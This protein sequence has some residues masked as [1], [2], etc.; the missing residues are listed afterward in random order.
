MSIN[1]NLLTTVNTHFAIV[2]PVLS[3]MAEDARNCPGR[4]QG[5]FVAIA[6]LSSV[7]PLKKLND[8]SVEMKDKKCIH[9]NFASV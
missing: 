6:S 5:E 3:E 4:L 7:T 1:S 2:S 9:K 8:P